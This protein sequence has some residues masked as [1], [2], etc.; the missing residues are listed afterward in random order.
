MPSSITFQPDDWGVALAVI[1]GT[2]I[3]KMIADYEANHVFDNKTGPDSSDDVPLG[4]EHINADGTVADLPLISR[5]KAVVLV[6]NCGYSACSAT[7]VDMELTDDQVIWSNLRTWI[8]SDQPYPN[9]GPWIFDRAQYL[10]AC[11]D[12]HDR[13]QN[14]RDTA[15]YMRT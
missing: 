14:D 7:T 11:Q 15:K 8:S 9:F 6:C 4:A 3:T 13:I 10:A 1:D 12:L 5:D 2:P